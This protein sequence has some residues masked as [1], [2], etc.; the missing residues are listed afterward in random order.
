VQEKKQVVNLYSKLAPNYESV[1]YIEQE[2]GQRLLD[3]LKYLKFEPQRI[4]D[5]GCGNGWLT[6]ELAA[7]YPSCAVIGVDFSKA[8]I[9]I[10]NQ[11]VRDNLS[12]IHAA[13]ED[14][15]SLNQEFSLVVSNCQ[16]IWHD[17]LEDNFLHLRK[18]LAKDGTLIFTTFGPNTLSEY[19]SSWQKALPRQINS[20][21]LDMHD[22]GDMLN[23]SF[24]RDCVLDREELAITFLQIQNLLADLKAGAYLQLHAKADQGLYT[25]KLLRK[26]FANYEQLR[27]NKTLPLTVE[28]IYGYAIAANA[29]IKLL[30]TETITCK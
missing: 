12:F 22:I 14:L 5:I 25:E 28:V 19:R 11:R 26:F 18:L 23:R 10:A 17:K 29:P 24:Y 6:E 15:P 16:L 8:M 21:F 30:Q 7:M 13:M 27:S 20:P 9:A 1:S 2:I 4:L 3:R